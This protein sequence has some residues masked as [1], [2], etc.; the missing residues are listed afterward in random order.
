MTCKHK[1]SG[2]KIINPHYN[3]VP[4]K[5]SKTKSHPEKSNDAVK[6]EIHFNSILIDSRLL[7][8]VNCPIFKPQVPQI[9]KPKKSVMHR[10]HTQ[11]TDHYISRK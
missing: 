4:S 6:C 9:T 5:C 3:R 1:K 2:H 10:N 7:E 8:E 11:R